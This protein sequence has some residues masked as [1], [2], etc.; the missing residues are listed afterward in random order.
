MTLNMGAGSQEIKQDRQEI[1]ILR[2]V[3]LTTKR[4]LET[5]TEA[6]GP[7]WHSLGLPDFST[8]VVSSSWLLPAS[9]IH[10]FAFLFPKL[11][12]PFPTQLPRSKGEL[13]SQR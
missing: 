11:V 13:I 7:A 2:G 10:P 8:F 9:P 6:Y 12:S 1:W 3:T 4:R 5:A